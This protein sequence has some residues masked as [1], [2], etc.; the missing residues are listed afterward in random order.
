MPRAA[1]S[2][3]AHTG[4]GG[5]GAAG[6]A[7][8]ATACASAPWNAS[9]TTCSWARE[10]SSSGGKRASTLA[11]FGS[12]TQGIGLGLPLGHVRA[13]GVR[14]GLCVAPGLGGQ[15][16]DALGQ[17]HRRLALHLHPVLQV[18]D[19]LDAIGQLR[20][21]PG[22]RLA[23]QGRAGLGGIALPG[24]GIGDVQARLGQHG[25]GLL[26]PL[27]SDRFLAAGA[28]D[29]VQPLAQ[30]PGRALVAGAQSRGTPPASA[31]RWGRRRAIRAGARRARPRWARKRH[32]RSARRAPGC[33]G[34]GGWLGS[35]RSVWKKTR[36]R[37]RGGRA[38]FSPRFVPASCGPANKKA[39][40]RPEAIC[41]A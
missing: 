18:L 13:Q 4:T 31:R 23:A 33:R 34:F 17:Q 15:H 25:L 20:L 36:P 12:A 29:L 19:A 28:L 7:S 22:Q 37:M 30:H 16:L 27:G 2:S 41:R 40:Q 14:R 24:H 5:N 32:R 21:Q 6:S 38:V 26:R 35:L 39:R 8:A 10:A 1:R 3:S 9:Q 11:Q